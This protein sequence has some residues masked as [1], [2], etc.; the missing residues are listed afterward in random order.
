LLVTGYNHIYIRTLIS[1]AIDTTV[2][3]IAGDRGAFVMS[4]DDVIDLEGHPGSGLRESA[5]FAPAA[6]PL[7]HLSYEGGIHARG[8]QGRFFRER[9]A[10]ACIRSRMELTW[11]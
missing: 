1:I 2:C 11:R 5:V 7:P 8:T 3:E 9:R 10:L 4:G 6:R